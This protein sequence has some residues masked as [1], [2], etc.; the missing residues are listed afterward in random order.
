MVLPG[1]DFYRFRKVNRLA[2]EGHED[3]S[4]ADLILTAEYVDEAPGKKAVVTVRFGGARLIRLPEMSPLFCLSEL[5]IEDVSDDQL[6]GVAYRTKDYG[7]GEFE[8]LS[9]QLEIIECVLR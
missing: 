8:V 9:R 5:E 6:E 3:I 1:F 4:S 2:V 7:S